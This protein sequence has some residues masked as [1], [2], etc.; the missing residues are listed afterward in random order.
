[1]EPSR[2]QRGADI[3]Q[4]VGYIDRPR[5]E[6][7]QNRNPSGQSDPRSPGKGQRPDD[8]DGGG[9]EAGEMPPCERQGRV[10]CPAHGACRALDAGARRRIGQDRRHLS[11]F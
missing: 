2:D 4:P 10:K 1:M 3:E 6:R 5:G 7:Q 9:V 8:S 11:P